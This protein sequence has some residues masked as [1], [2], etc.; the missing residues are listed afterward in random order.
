MENIYTITKALDEVAG[1]MAVF[2]AQQNS[3][4]TDS[5]IQGVREAYP[6]TVHALN[7]LYAGVATRRLR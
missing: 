4:V 5:A 6:L 7:A 1:R 2:L 3:H